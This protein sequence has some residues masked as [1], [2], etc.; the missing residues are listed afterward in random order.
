M[1][2][3]KSKI[4][5]ILR[6]PLVR[7]V[8]FV[9]IIIVFVLCIS[10]LFK[11]N[12]GSKNDRLIG[13]QRLVNVSDNGEYTYLDLDGKTKKY[14]GY[15][16]MSDFYYD[17]TNVSRE[18]P[19]DAAVTEYALINK[20]GGQVVKFGKYENII[21]VIGGKYYK[22]L[23][24]N[25]FGIVDYEGKTILEP[26]YEYISVITVQDGSQFVFECQNADTYDFINESGKVLMTTNTAQHT[27][28]YINRLNENFDTIVKVAIDSE[29]K[30]Y[31][32]RTGE[33]LF[34]GESI[35]NLSYNI[36]KQEGKIII[37]NKDYKKNIA[38]DTS[39][40]Y[41]ADA[42]AYFN[43]YILVEQKNVSTGTKTYKY[44]VYDENLKVVTQSENK[45]NIVKAASG[46]IYFLTNELD[47][48]NITNE[49]KK[50]KKV[51]GYEFNSN[52][53]SDLQALILN[54]VGDTSTY[55]LYNFKGKAL[56]E[57]VQEYY[58]KGSSLKVTS[59]EGKSFL[60]FTNNSRYDLVDQDSVNSTN[61]YLTVENLQN[62]TTS[63][64]THEGKVI[65]DRAVGTKVFY[66]DNY[67]G[68][69]E[70]KT[71]RIYNVKT[72]KQTY[73]YQIGDY[74]DRDE[75]V[76]YVELTT[77]YYLFTGKE[78]IKK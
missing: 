38:L 16:S 25:K 40:D 33:E 10:K 34:A 8:L 17:V 69:Q 5:D 9:L 31:N 19:K 2:R 30:Y 6:R 75:T 66:N 60:L 35:S 67:I 63:V 56:E 37:Y 78:L 54:P 7:L 43:K 11:G 42:R 73:S 36:L 13:Y 39:A 15:K 27:V 4:Q 22:V 3:K 52:S 18:N 28:S 12:S 20:N 47:G 53:I 29:N 55:S 77:G 48:V 74:I 44:T 65:I 51:K 23:S 57:K 70:D 59:K 21:Q 61:E 72:G 32:L 26:K 41:S 58:Y 1:A 49:D 76:N 62:G 71:V 64:I 24:D 46:E 50:T 14:D 68:L 45:I